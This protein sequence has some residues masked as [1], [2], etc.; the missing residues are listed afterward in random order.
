MNAADSP[1]K[2][3]LDRENVMSS[4]EVPEYHKEATDG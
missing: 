3:V 4:G 1:L 2:L